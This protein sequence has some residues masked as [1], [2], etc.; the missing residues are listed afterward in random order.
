[1]MHQQDERTFKFV[2]VIPLRAKATASDWTVTCRLLDDTLRS[3]LAASKKAIVILVTSDDPA[4]SSDLRRNP[5]LHIQQGHYWVPHSKQA[6]ME[7]KYTKLRDGLEHARSQLPAWVMRMDADDLLSRRFLDFCASS[8]RSDHCAIDCGF[9]WEEG[10]PHVTRVRDFHRL[11]GSSL[12]S[13]FEFLPEMTDEHWLIRWGHNIAIDNLTARGDSIAYS[14]TPAAI[15]R[16]AT[17]ENH[18][19]LGWSNMGNSRKV[20]IKRWLARRRFTPAMRHEF[21]LE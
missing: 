13:Y 2:A 20:Q 5:R 17:G 8:P 4:I 9:V 11:C 14:E 12:A 10:S 21:G 6:Q 1:M 18:S 3:I 16:V 19:G 7:D 15:Y